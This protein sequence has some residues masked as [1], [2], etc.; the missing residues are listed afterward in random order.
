VN[1]QL[2]LAPMVRLAVQLLLLTEKSVGSL[3]PRGVTPKVTAAPFAVTE[4]E[5]QELV[6]PAPVLGQLMLETLVVTDAPVP[7]TLKD[8]PVPLEGLTVAEADFAPTVVGLN[9]IVPLEQV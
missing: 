4:T 3:L 1:V 8:A 2:L 5:P 6:N 7:E 9:R